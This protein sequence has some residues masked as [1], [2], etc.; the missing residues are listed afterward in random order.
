MIDAAT[1]LLLRAGRTGAE[2]L[3]VQRHPGLSFMGGLW[4]FPGGRVE[5]QDGI[6]PAQRAARPLDDAFRHAAC[7]E[8]LEE[9]A[10]ALVPEQLQLWSRWI[11]PSAAAR[12]FDTR[13]YATR[14]AR[15]TPIALDGTELVAHEWLPPESAVR[16]ALEGALPVSPPTL[17]V[18][19]D[20]RLSLAQHG[21]LD[22]TLAAERA[23]TVPP[24]MPRL[25]TTASGPEA[26]MPWEAEYAAL[27]GEGEPIAAD[28][29]PHIARLAALP[30][31]RIASVIAP[32][33]QQAR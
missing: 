28:S 23:R 31:R 22:A 27:P 3:I 19:E 32:R 26:V 2:V 17:L 16:R 12:R 1:V 21:A 11:T 4:A 5:P 25:R 33:S 6:D 24:I 10:V 18:L 14:V 7:R 13:F 15:E 29:A 9:C 20:L 8:L 30:V